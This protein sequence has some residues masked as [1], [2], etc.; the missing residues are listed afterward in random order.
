MALLSVVESEWAKLGLHL[1]TRKTKVMAFNT[2]DTSVPTKDC[3]VG[4]RGCRWIQI[5]Q[6]A[7]MFPQQN[8]TLRFVKLW[9]GVPYTQ[10]REYG[11]TLYDLDDNLKRQLFLATVESVLLYGAEVWTL[12]VQQEESL[13][14]VYTMDTYCAA[15]R[16]PQWG[17]HHGHLL[18]SKKSSS[19]GLTP[20]YYGQ[21]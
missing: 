5:P 16:V 11:G 18:W 7:L 12:T 2:R 6:A 9:H 4:I 13:N 8:G 21:L 19:M 20:G 15:R 1:S 17:L 3:I 10:W 14:G